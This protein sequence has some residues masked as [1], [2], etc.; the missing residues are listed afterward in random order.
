MTINPDLL[1][2]IKKQFN[3][4][5]KFI[6]AVW[7]G[8]EAV[9]AEAFSVCATVSELTGKLGNQW[10]S[11]DYKFSTNK[12]AANVLNNILSL[13]RPEQ[14]GRALDVGCGYGGFLHAFN[15]CGFEPHGVEINPSLIALAEANLSD[16]DFEYSIELKD[17]FAN[18]CG[19]EKFDLITLND[20]IEHLLDPRGAMK[21]LVN[22]LNPGGVL[23]L[24][25]PNGKS[26]FY[27]TV[28]PHSRVFGA[29]CLPRSLA[30]PLVQGALNN[31]GYKYTLGEYLP[32]EVFRNFADNHGLAFKFLSTIWDEK[33]ENASLYMREFF[34][35]WHRSNINVVNDRILAREIETH[36]WNYVA[37]FAKS[38]SHATASCDIQSFVNTYLSRAWTVVLKKI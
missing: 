10:R 8:L 25:A 5:E 18:T 4:G 15:K 32:L 7:Q 33:P 9:D 29:S 37:E 11:I 21:Q 22:M 36:L 35:A 28:D 20:V 31:N 14:K 16:A 2:E 30:K 12:R 38:A 23:A 34:D 3:V 17:I 26:I 6:L 13:D 1:N 24:Y 19:D 27:A